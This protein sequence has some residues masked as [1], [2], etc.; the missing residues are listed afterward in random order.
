[1]T[2]EDFFYGNGDGVKKAK[3]ELEIPVVIMAGGKGNRLA[4]FTHVLPKPLIPVG[5]KTILELIIDEFRKF[6]ITRYYFTLNFRGEMIRAYFDGVEKEYTV[7]YV[8]EE[9]FYGT[10]GSLKLL[11]EKISPTFIVSNCDIILKAEYEKVLSFHRETEA[12]LTVLSSIQH[13]KIPY[14]VIEFSNGGKV[15]GIREKP[16][17]TFPINTGVYVVNKECLEYIPEKKV[18]NMTDLIEVLIA[19]GRKVFT[20]P[21]NEKDYTDIG[22]WEEYRKTLDLIKMKQGV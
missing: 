14:G 13:H 9:D 5:E 20:Y 10:A 15:T 21:V 18:F 22:Q 7:S 1:L 19:D 6:G 3:P 4:P 16:E 2:W 8:W 12:D 11:E 17:Y